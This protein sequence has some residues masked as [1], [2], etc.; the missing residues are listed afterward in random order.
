[1]CESIWACPC[2]RNWTLRQLRGK[3]WNR[4]PILFRWSQLP[5]CVS[6][7]CFRRYAVSRLLSSEFYKR[8]FSFASRSIFT[9][10]LDAPNC[11]LFS[12]LCRI[13]CTQDT[14]RIGC[15]VIA[16]Y[17]EQRKSQMQVT[18]NGALQYAVVTFP[19]LIPEVPAQV[20]VTRCFIPSKLKN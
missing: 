4:P 7:I 5:P 16:R 6:I 13:F 11:S 2:V 12:S 17:V 9:Q 18:F 8:M 15:G 14:W 19:F 20:L 1:M 3:E 10:Y